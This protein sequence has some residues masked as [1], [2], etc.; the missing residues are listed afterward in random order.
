MMKYQTAFS[1][2]SKDSIH[3]LQKRKASKYE[4]TAD[5]CLTGSY[6]QHLLFL[7]TPGHR[8]LNKPDLYLLCL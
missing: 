6:D 4:I 1:I 2:I 3:L 8:R 5:R 7:H